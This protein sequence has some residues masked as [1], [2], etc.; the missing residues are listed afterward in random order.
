MLLLI[1]GSVGYALLSSGNTGSKSVAKLSPPP[2]QTT[3]GLK[4]DT[5]QSITQGQST[6]GGLSVDGSNAGSL[7]S[8]LGQSSSSKA[9]TQLPTPDAFEQYDQY[10]DE[11]SVL[12]AETAV[13]SGKEA[14]QNK[15]VAVVYKGWLTNGQLFDQSKTNQQGVLEPIVFTLGGGQVIMG[16]EQGIAG[17]KVG[18]KRRLIVPP[19]A[20]YGASAQ[21][22][23][24]ANSVLVFDVELVDAE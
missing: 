11:Q 1:G 24:P 21:G 8:N 16:W 23:I 22:Q 5:S 13:G 6:G 20:G 19:S 3:S 14:T 15:K 2:K 17:M 4:T 9:G 7:Q 10:K 12:Y 18:G